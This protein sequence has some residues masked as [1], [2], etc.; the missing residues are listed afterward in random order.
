MS[1]LPIDSLMTWYE[2]K[3]KE[4]F[5]VF[6]SD[7]GKRLGGIKQAS[8]DI[9]LVLDEI[10]SLKSTQEDENLKAALDR[11]IERV[12]STLQSVTYP[13]DLTYSTVGDFLSRI[14]RSVADIFD[15]GKRWIPRFRGRKYKSVIVDLDKHFPRA[16]QG[17]TGPKFRLQALRSPREGRTCQRRYPG[18]K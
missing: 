2:E 3:T 5:S 11:F 7:T 17:N 13:D 6:A 1:E 15:A 16:D 12:S 10:N 14:E 4:L 18:I 8:R 9:K